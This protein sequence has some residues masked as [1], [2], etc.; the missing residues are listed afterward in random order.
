MKNKIK[1]K[2]NNKVSNIKLTI[3]LPDLVRNITGAKDSYKKVTND[4]DKIFR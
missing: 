4:I 2:R 1:K 3:N